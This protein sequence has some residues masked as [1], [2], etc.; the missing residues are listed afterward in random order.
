MIAFLS[1]YMVYWGTQ[2]NGFMMD[3]MYSLMDI[4][5][6]GLIRAHFTEGFL[7]TWHDASELESTIVLPE[8]NAFSYTIRHTTNLFFLLLHTA[9][10]F[11]PGVFSIWPAMVLNIITYIGALI[12]IYKLSMYFIN[13]R[14]LALLPSFIW[15]ISS[16]AIN[17]VVFIRFYMMLTFLCLV[18][19]YLIFIAIKN[20]FKKW[21]HIAAILVI[22]II[23]TFMH[24]YFFVY[25]F[26]ISALVCVYLLSI[27]AFKQLLKFLSPILIGIMANQ[28][29]LQISLL[30]RLTYGRQGPAAIQSLLH[31]N[32]GYWDR[33]DR[34]LDIIC[35]AI[36]GDINQYIIFAVC[37]ILIVIIVV[38]YTSSGE[39]LHELAKKQKTALWMIMGGSSVFC[40]MMIARIAPEQTYRYISYITPFTVILFVSLLVHALRAIGFKSIITVFAIITIPYSV[41]LM[42]N[43]YD[44]FIYKDQYSTDK[45]LSQ[46][47]DRPVVS[48][49]NIPQDIATNYYR[50]FKFEN[51]ILFTT[52]DSMDID[53]IKEVPFDRGLILLLPKRGELIEPD[54][55]LGDLG[56]STYTHMFDTSRHF[57]YYM[58]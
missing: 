1:A 39:K 24:Q 26:F 43:I 36:F 2:K 49:N 25:A 6:G 4:R 37:V 14:Y 45:E 12:V 31:G 52:T 33:I 44:V 29:I 38:A 16:A 53:L 47:Y 56:L 13:D 23:G 41:L 40:L 21:W 42:C 7:N 57:L 46:Y 50:F 9:Y 10:S 8:E 48:I 58:E 17:L 30:R 18:L 3:E 32:T 20:G 54:E 35:R 27:R 55:I 22:A 11:Q 5:G 34:Y 19:T 51:Q 28:I 15:G